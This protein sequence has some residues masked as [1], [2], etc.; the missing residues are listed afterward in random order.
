MRTRRRLKGQWKEEKSTSKFLG[1]GNKIFKVARRP[2]DGV[3]VA[4]AI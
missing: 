2:K 4:F 3:L 1:F